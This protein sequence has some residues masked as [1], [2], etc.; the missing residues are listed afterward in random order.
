M[1]KVFA[2]PDGTRTR[3]ISTQ[4]V[5]FKD[6]K[7]AWADID[8]TLVGDD[9]RPG[10]LRNRANAWT[11]RFAP[12]PAGMTVETN[13][14]TVEL[15]P[16]GAAQVAPEVEPGGNAVIYRDAWP[17]VDLRYQVL[18]GEVKEDVIIRRQPG[19]ASFSFTTKGQGFEADR[20]SPGGLAPVGGRGVRLAPPEV[21]DRDGKPVEAARPSLVKA[22]QG[23]TSEAHL[24]V[25]PR[26]L[27]SLPPEAF[28]I[29]LDPSV[30]IGIRADRAYKSDGYS[31]M[32]WHRVGNSRD[33]GDRY[34]RTVAYFGYESLYGK[35]I[36]DAS[37][38]EWNRAAGTAN[39]YPFHVFHATAW[40]FNG[41]GQYFGSTTAGND[42]R[43]GSGAMTAAYDSWAQQGVGAA[44][45]LV[46]HEAGGLYTYK[47]FNAFALSLTYDNM[48]TVATPVAPSP[49]NGA[50]VHSAT[51]TLAASS[52]EPT[53]TPSTTTSG[54]PPART[55]PAPWCGNRVGARP[56][57]CRC[58]P[59][60]WPW[61][62]R[63][64]G[65]PTCTTGGS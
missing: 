34:W 1:A 6:P 63:T 42:A 9:S 3:R 33:N 4:P 50:S 45:M 39:G 36:L 2:N 17:G 21:I 59:T 55:R 5:H 40:G 47:Q 26:W 43:V 28:P 56:L 51:P 44:L 64:T 13:D 22:G 46:G 20:D 24:S 30:Q 16:K 14:A 60:C 11:V 32:C 12:L 61:A 41:V 8:N 54:S 65:T 29:S 10:V 27:K 18:G 48:P 25:D 23:S 37:V 57:R 53:A 52:Y 19:R 15:S 62:R 58:P 31:C 49:P 38:S 35:R 7:G